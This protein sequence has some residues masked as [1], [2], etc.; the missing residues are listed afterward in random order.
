MIAPKSV[1][2]AFLAILMVSSGIVV[3]FL[4]KHSLPA[5]AS[6]KSKFKSKDSR[7]A[8]PASVTSFPIPSPSILAI[9]IMIALS[10]NFFI[11]HN[12]IRFFI[13]IS[14]FNILFYVFLY[15]N[16]FQF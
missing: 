2:L 15:Y 13:I 12:L 4:S 10:L 1:A 8:T 6:M 14:L 5:S 11:C 9:F 16:L 3:P 7:T